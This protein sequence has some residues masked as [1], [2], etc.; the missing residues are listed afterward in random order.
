MKTLV[1]FLIPLFVFLMT[2]LVYPQMKGQVHLGLGSGLINFSTF[3][4]GISGS[5]YNNFSEGSETDNTRGSSSFSFLVGY[6]PINNLR[7]DGGFSINAFEYT[8][9]AIYFNLGARYFYYSNKKI[10]LNG[11]L[12]ANFGISTGAERSAYLGETYNSYGYYESVYESRKP[13]N[14]SIT[15]FEFQ[16]WPLEGGALTA[17]FTYSW[18]FL[19]GGDNNKEKS[20]GINVGLLIRLN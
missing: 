17:D 14:L 20:F 7:A 4:T 5:L 10:M 1:K 8:E 16:F 6:F 3:N 18:L 2:G 13:I 15:P 9:P 19:N 11:G 12:S